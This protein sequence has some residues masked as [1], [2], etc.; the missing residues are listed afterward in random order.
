[1]P[2]QFFTGSKVEHLDQNFEVV[3][4]DLVTNIDLEGQ[5]DKEHD[6]MQGYDKSLL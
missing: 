2:E 4:S 3:I 1:M 6:Q 5:M